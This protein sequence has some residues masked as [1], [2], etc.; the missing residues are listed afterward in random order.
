MLVVLRSDCGGFG[1][2]SVSLGG[3]GVVISRVIRRVA[4]LITH[5]REL[6]TPLISTL[7]P[8]P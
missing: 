8:K 2:F 7:T 3:S 5:I 1:D 6:T 4:I